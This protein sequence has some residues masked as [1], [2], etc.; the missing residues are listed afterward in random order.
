MDDEGV[1][2]FHLFVEHLPEIFV[3]PRLRILLEYRRG[4]LVIEIAQGDDGFILAAGEVILAHSADADTSDGRLVAGSLIARASQ[5]GTRNDQ[6]RHAR[7]QRSA[8]GYRL[9]G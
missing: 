9:F 6:R 8:P 1:E 4:K 5:H 3:E 7:C 2:V